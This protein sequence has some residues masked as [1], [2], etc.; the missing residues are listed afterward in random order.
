MKD[1]FYTRCY[2]FLFS[3]FLFFFFLL[4]TPRKV[5]FILKQIDLDFDIRPYFLLYMGIPNT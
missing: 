3:S 5:I 1:V 2:D 4:H